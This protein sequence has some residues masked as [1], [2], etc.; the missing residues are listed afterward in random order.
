MAH[1]ISTGKRG[2]PECMVRAAAS[3]PH[4]TQNHLGR[5]RPQTWISP[6]KVVSGTCLPSGAWASH[7]HFSNPGQERACHEA[8]FGVLPR[9]DG[10]LPATPGPLETLLA[11]GAGGHVHLASGSP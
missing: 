11:S 6:A 2:G 9:G 3:W 8:P 7:L 1:L 10:A 4:G 5:R